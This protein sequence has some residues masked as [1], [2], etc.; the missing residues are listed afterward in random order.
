MDFIFSST[1]YE[2]QAIRRAE[3]VDLA[4]IPVP[5][6]SA[7]DL[8]LHKLLAGR[9]RDI[10]DVTGV[11]SRKGSALDWEYLLR[12]AREFAVVAGREHLPERIAELRRVGDSFEE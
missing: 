11:V 2:V 4:G 8:I 10:E 1:P 12:W 6:A 3:P 7:E 5:F 9:P